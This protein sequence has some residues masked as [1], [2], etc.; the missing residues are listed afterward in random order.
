MQ[1][2]AW[3]TQETREWL[4]KAEDDLRAG[5]LCMRQRRPLLWIAAYHAQQAAEKALKAFLTWHASPFRKT[6]NLREVGEPCWTIDASLRP[7]IER[8]LP[9]SEFAWKHRYPG[10]ALDPSRDEALEA[11]KA[12]QALFSAILE[13]LPVEVRPA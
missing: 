2:E 4:A 7:V 3:V 5:D 13:R 10:E 9:L 6:H 12:A 8:A 1:P 11:V